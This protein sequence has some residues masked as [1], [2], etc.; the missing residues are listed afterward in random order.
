[1][2]ITNLSTE[3][4]CMHCSC[5][6]RLVCPASAKPIKGWGRA[7]TLLLLFSLQLTV[8][9]G[10]VH[11][12]ASNKGEVSGVILDSAG[13][14]VPGAK[15]Q[16][17]EV[18]TGFGR[19]TV[20]NDSGVYV[21]ASLEPGEYV[22]TVTADGFEPVKNSRISVYTGAK[23]VLD[24]ALKPEGVSESVTVRPAQEI[25]QPADVS[26]STTVPEWQIKNLPLNDKV[27]SE[28][29]RLEAGVTP[30]GLMTAESTGI[31][32]DTGG[33]L[34]GLRQFF[35]HVTL[36]GGHFNEPAFP[37]GTLTNTQGI[38]FEAVKELKIN[39]SNADASLAGTFGY[40]INITTRS[41]TSEHHGS[42]YEYFRNNVFDARGFFD[43]K[44]S[45]HLI[46]HQFGGSLGG[47]IPLRHNKDFYFVNYE[48][49]RR[50]ETKVIN[51]VVPTDRLLAAVPGG[52]ENGYLREL[53]FYSY[54]R[55]QAG[56][57]SPAG[58]AAAAA[59]PVDLGMR[60]DGFV[61]RLDSAL[62]ARHRGLARFNVM[63]GDA[64]PGVQ[65]ASGVR[66]ANGGFIWRFTNF[67]A[68]VSSTLS[69]SVTNEFHFTFDRTALRLVADPTPPE[70]VSLGFAPSG[71]SPNGLPFVLFVGTGLSPLGPRPNVPRA[72][73]GTVYEF[74]DMISAVHKG[75]YFKFGGILQHTDI[76]WLQGENTRRSPVFIGF[77][78]PFDNSFFGVTTARFVSQTQN[79]NLDPSFIHRKFQFTHGE[80]FFQDAYR[81]SNRL[82]LFGG[83][84]YSLDTPISEAN[85]W[86]SNAYPVGPHGPI[87]DGDINN[88]T[89]HHLA[90]KTV[91]QLRFSDF[92][93]GAI[94]P[95]IG[96][97]LTLG[98]ARKT[99]IKASYGITYGTQ[100][101]E[102]IRLA[103]VNPPFGLSTS[104]GPNRFGTV[105]DPTRIQTPVLN[106]FNPSTVKPRLQHWNVTVER[107][108]YG[109]SVLRVSYIGNRGSSL[110]D[111][112][113]PNFG[114]G[115]QGTRPNKDFSVINLVESR[116]RSQYN[117]LRM[118]VQRRFHD[119]FAIQASYVFGK[120]ADDISASVTTFQPT[121]VGSLPTNQFDLRENWGTSDFDVRHNAVVNFIYELP[122]GR[123]RRWVK[124]GIGSALLG[125]W[126]VTGII[127]YWDGFPF[128]VIS[129]VD[130]NGDGVANDRARVL[131][132][133]DPRRALSS[134][135]R[136]QFLD[137]QSVG[138]IFSATEGTALKRNFFRGPDIFNMD[139]EGR[140]QFT[141]SKDVKLEL[142]FEVFN[143]FNKANFANPVSSIASP[144][145]GQIINTV[146]EPRQMQ[147]GLRTSF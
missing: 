65:I 67:L 117:G 17:R 22:L 110:W 33:W 129:G 125:G 20:S 141:I 32:S 103:G 3:D 98:E 140:R 56:T 99:V 27:L 31:S 68:G 116:G 4:E 128:D 75:H 87:E 42:L 14:I 97:S 12:Q 49:F 138:T 80:M 85:G 69:N 102:L 26:L 119:G 76:L 64:N 19:E 108:I 9:P 124:N 15:V 123:D 134:G 112:R 46:R 147:F 100:W 62:G 74:A 92:Y 16:L 126:T 44:D 41:G 39:K 29:T 143:I 47:P 72:K 70:L 81:A 60:R 111:T 135:S 7:I 1:M 122:F 118:E 55:P 40:S 86:L 10:P 95:N 96:A 73:R 114:S 36:D 89:V 51:V 142:T 106:A 63:D 77:G 132:G 101:F 105:A 137:P 5:P 61:A 88:E 146:M 28:F 84:N 2:S 136:T 52:A 113:Q 79:F 34:Y 139:F 91:D 8:Q 131:P 54:P 127:S 23:L 57:F 130:S 66:G 109:D 53:M 37:G 133:A 11:A 82:M 45:E 90:I 50:A 38:G 83:V 121:G 107:E 71:E 104:L 78:P 94:A 48:G 25:I 21:V 30:R 115:F 6:T 58:L 93:K 13:S 43:S 145:F 120:S 24:V 144:V 18:N 59:S 35:M